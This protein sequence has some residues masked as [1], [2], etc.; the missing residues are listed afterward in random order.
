MARLSI[1]GCWMFVTNDGKYSP[2]TVLAGYYAVFILLLLFNFFFNSERM[3]KE[4]HYWTGMYRN[5]LLLNSIYL[6]LYLIITTIPRV[7]SELTFLRPFLQ[8]LRLQG[9]SEGWKEESPARVHPGETESL[10]LPVLL[11]PAGSDP[12]HPGHPGQHPGVHPSGPTRQQKYPDSNDLLQSA[13]DWLGVLHRGLAHQHRLLL[14]P[15]LCR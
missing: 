1:F 8:L 3:S 13:V 12:A 4:G 11:P 6:F 14:H 2:L 5:Y 9:H 10:L 15:S 7:D